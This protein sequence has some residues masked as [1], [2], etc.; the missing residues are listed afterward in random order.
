MGHTIDM[1][2]VYC[3]MGIT[4]TNS[5]YSR[6]PVFFFMCLFLSPTSQYGDS[7]IDQVGRKR[8]PDGARLDVNTAPV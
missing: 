8:K 5:I 2:W 4:H 3:G 6:V 7:G 1:E